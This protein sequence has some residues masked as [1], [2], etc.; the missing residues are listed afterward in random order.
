L[1]R[2]LIEGVLIGARRVD[3]AKARVNRARGVYRA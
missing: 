3:S 2:K 1:K